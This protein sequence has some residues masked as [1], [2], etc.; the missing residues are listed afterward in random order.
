VTALQRNRNSQLRLRALQEIAASR[1]AEA[2][3]T[4]IDIMACWPRDERRD[5]VKIML[6]SLAERRIGP[7]IVR[8]M[9]IEAQAMNS[10]LSQP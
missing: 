8:R 5:G 9:S 3:D 2:F 1:D 6:Q 4:A 10:R 7:G